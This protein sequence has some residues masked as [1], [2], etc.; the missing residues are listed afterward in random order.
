MGVLI[1]EV[2]ADSPPLRASG[3]GALPCKTTPKPRQEISRRPH[4]EQHGMTQ[5]R[6]FQEVLPVERDEVVDPGG[7]RRS[8]DLRI[9]RMGD[10]PLA[11]RQD[12]STGLGSDLDVDPVEQDGERCQCVGGFAAD[13]A[14][15]LRQNLAADDDLDSAGFAQPQQHP[16]ATFLGPDGGEQ[17]A[18]IKKRPGR[19]RHSAR[20]LP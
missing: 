19:R 5:F 8:Q 2:I 14:F 4:N 15:Q 18:G 11:S 17:G 20:A 6:V 1:G 10:E 9:A 12:F 7:N 3:R 16:S 13:C